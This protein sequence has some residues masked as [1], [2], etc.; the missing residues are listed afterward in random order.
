MKTTKIYTPEEY[1]EK[2]MQEKEAFK[3]RMVK[4]KE[5]SENLS[6]EA[7]ENLAQEYFRDKKLE[8][9]LEN[10]ALAHQFEYYKEYLK[11]STN[12]NPEGILDEMKFDAKAKFLF[13]YNT[14][15][16]KIGIG[17]VKWMDYRLND[18]DLLLK[19]YEKFIAEDRRYTDIKKC[20]Y[21]M[22]T[23]INQLKEEKKM[24]RTFMDTCPVGL[25]ST[26]NRLHP[27]VRKI[28]LFI[29]Q[30]GILIAATYFLLLSNLHTITF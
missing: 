18:I 1:L 21:A 9:E 30:F 10:Q 19:R 17:K 27:T 3:E 2:E 23:A 6:E 20:H 14:F 15:R 22:D 12:Y 28:V 29:Y 4:F 7:F 26:K 5:A 13:R 24:L 8:K 25:T 11:K 16:G